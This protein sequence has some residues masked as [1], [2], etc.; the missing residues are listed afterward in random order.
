[1]LQVSQPAIAVLWSVIFLGSSV[2]GI[3]IVGMALV[4]VGLVAVTVQTQRARD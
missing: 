4:I 1:M 2:R 3:Q